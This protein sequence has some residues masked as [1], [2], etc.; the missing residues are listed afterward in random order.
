MQ[1]AAA[2]GKRVSGQELEIPEMAPGPYRFCV[3]RGPE[4][5]CEAGLLAR[6][7]TLSLTIR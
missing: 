4:I 1:W 5:T 2:H 3:N 6:G 7:S